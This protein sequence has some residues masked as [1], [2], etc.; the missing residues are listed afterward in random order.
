MGH[1]GAALLFYN[2]LIGE[3]NVMDFELNRND[4]WVTD[5]DT[6]GGGGGSKLFADMF[7]ILK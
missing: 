1:F 2:E 4:T 5:Q 7:M 6:N 3:L